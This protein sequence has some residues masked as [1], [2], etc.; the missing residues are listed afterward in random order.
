MILRLVIILG[1][2]YLL[3]RVVRTMIMSPRDGPSD[4]GGGGV[5][6]MVQDPFC[7][8]YIPLRDAVKK[9]IGGETHYFCSE[10]C[11]DKFEQKNKRG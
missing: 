6:S 5:S 11:L 4:R 8:T 9:V 7:K 2:A 3:Y 10:E 1:L